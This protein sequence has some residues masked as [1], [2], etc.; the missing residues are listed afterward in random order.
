MERIKFLTIKFANDIRGFDISKFRG[1]IIEAAGKEHVLFHNHDENN[2]RY[3]YPLIQY[4]QI[5]RKPVIICI[6]EGV[7]EIHHF[8]DNWK[9]PVMIGGE[10]CN[11]FIDK[12]YAN[13]YLMRTRDSMFNYRIRNWIALN[14]VNYPKYKSNESLA[15]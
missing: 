11:L 9:N 7:D 4:K 1:A 10:Q 5:N 12:I 8:F 13:Q 6:K 14:Q 2:F 15:G 3:S